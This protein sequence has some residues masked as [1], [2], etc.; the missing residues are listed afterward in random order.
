[1][2][3]QA[4]YGKSKGSPVTQAYGDVLFSYQLRA[5]NKVLLD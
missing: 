5:R 4:A 2:A 1:V 3:L